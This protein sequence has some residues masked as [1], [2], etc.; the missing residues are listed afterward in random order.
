MGAEGYVAHLIVLEVPAFDLLVL[1]G[2]EE[3]GLSGADSQGPHT[4]DVA[5]QCQL[6]TTRC[7]LPQLVV[8]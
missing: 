1:A 8:S 2:R 4:T 7:Q 6:Q 3:V 5:S